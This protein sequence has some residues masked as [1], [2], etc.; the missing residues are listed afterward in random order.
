M[1]EQS[2]PT[3]VRVVLFICIVIR[4]Y[5]QLAFSAEDRVQSFAVGS[6]GNF[7]VS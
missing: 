1:R 2:A 3:G 4:Q 5:D 7:G 6:E